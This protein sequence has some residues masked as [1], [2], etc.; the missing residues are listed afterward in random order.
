[1][2]VTEGL[3]FSQMRTTVST[4]QARAYAAAN[5]ASSGKRVAKGSD[6]PTSYARGMVMRQGLAKLEAME[7][8]GSVAVD[9]LTTADDALAASEAAIT[10]AREIAIASANATL[11][12]AD[13][14]GYAEEVAGL[15][16]TILQQANARSG[17]TYVFAGG[18]SSAPAYST[19]GTY[20][21]DANV[22]AVEVAPGDMVNANTPGSAIFTPASGVSAFD[23]LAR[24]EAN[25]RS[26][27]I[28][29]VTAQLT[30]LDTVHS[31]ITV[32]R[33]N[34]GLDLQRA[35]AAAAVRDSVRVQIEGARSAAVDADTV[36][37]YSALMQAQQ[38]LESAIAAAQRMMQ[39][40]QNGLTF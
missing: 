24:L 36:G 12:P 23:V 26:S 5:V 29:A 25:L 1:M 35:N 16:Q 14:L 3:T 40:M 2:R 11:S 17:E 18:R 20:D 37:S 6:D 15:R 30:E 38:A 33:T 28:P 13:R 22:R 27:N 7:R 9:H 19:A 8:G 34:V 21:G 32:G 31:Q 4:A 39:A 10:R